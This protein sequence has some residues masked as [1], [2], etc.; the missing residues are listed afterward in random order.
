MTHDCKISITSSGG[1]GCDGC[2]AEFLNNAFTTTYTKDFKV[3][4]VK[5]KKATLVLKPKNKLIGFN[6][7]KYIGYHIAIVRGKY[8]GWWGEIIKWDQ[9]NKNFRV[10]CYGYDD[11]CSD[12]KK[13]YATLP[14]S[15]LRTE[16]VVS[17]RIKLKLT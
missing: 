1:I 11:E 17:K 7:V 15:A 14:P 9:K 16:H 6:G 5:N 10:R 12:M 2:A 4:D 13:A 3:V 8:K